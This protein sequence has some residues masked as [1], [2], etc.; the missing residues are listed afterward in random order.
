[1]FDNAYKHKENAIR[2]IRS[3]TKCVALEG[4]AGVAEFAL[5]YRVSDTAYV[6]LRSPSAMV[7]LKEDNKYTL[8]IGYADNRQQFAEVIYNYFTD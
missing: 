6:I 3:E 8:V 4:Y 7:E 1:M 2:H 5:V